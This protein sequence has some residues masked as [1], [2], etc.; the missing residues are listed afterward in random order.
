VDRSS[1]IFALSL[2]FCVPVFAATDSKKLSLRQAIDI[3]VE[4]S[5][6]LSTARSELNVRDLEYANSYSVF[7]PSLDL[8]ATHGLRGSNPSIYKNI[9]ASELGLQL[10]ESLYDNG[11]SLV[12][13]ESARFQK[14][15]AELSYRNERDKLVLDVGFEYM[16]YSL[17]A[18]LAQV[19]EQQFNIVNKQYQ[20]VSNQYQ[21]GVKT[22]RDYL[23]FKTELRR[24][25]IELQ[26]SRATVAKSRLELMRLLGFDVNSQVQ[27]FDFDPVDVDVKSVE[28]VPGQS[29]DLTNHYQYRIAELRRKSFENDVYIVR[30]DYW[31]QLFLTAEAAY[32][33]GDYL[34]TSTP[35]SQNEMTSWSALLTLKFNL[36]DWGIRHRNISIADAKR[37]QSENAITASLNTF[38]S[39]NA[40][41]MLQLNQSSKNF[42]IARELLDLETKSYGFLDSEYRNG[43]VSYLD[44]IVGLRDLLN[45]KVQMYTS[46]FDLRGQ[47]LRY[48]YHEGRLYESVSKK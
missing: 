20:S 4:K 36:W 38:S 2:S 23:R 18:N 24:S 21:L 6:S 1:V 15:I 12:K 44:I 17:A 5:P 40:K 27:P 47:L 10:T 35:L 11:I 8:S 28:Q 43:K 7:L 19:Q 9:Y 30:R 42:A 39:E 32:H 46:Y 22:R 48:R 26:N 45:A 29:P 25:E 37:I 14:E 34:G 3:A 31:P 16:R 33:T 41:M 13:Y